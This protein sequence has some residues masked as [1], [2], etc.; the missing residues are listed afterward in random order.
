MF[1]CCLIQLSK[2]TFPLLVALV[3]PFFLTNSFFFCFCS[4]WCFINDNE[5]IFSTFN[6]QFLI[7]ICQNWNKNCLVTS[8]L[9]V[10]FFSMYFSFHLHIFEFK[11]LVMY[12]TMKL[13]LHYPMLIFLSYN[14]IWCKRKISI[15]IHFQG[16]ECCHFYS[17][18]P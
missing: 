14:I 10:T 1:C 6:L 3:Y 7:W 8:H 9:F 11:M 5:N 17:L 18:V 16:M 2:Q 13:F 4:L 12:V 15:P